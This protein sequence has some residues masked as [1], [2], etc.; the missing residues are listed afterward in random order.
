MSK[1]L[2][3]CRD[4]GTT[5]GLGVYAR[6]DLQP[7]MEVW[8]EP[9]EEIEFRQ[10]EI[11]QMTLEQKRIL[12]RYGMVKQ[13]G[14]VC[15]SPHAKVWL[16]DRRG[17]VDARFCE[18]VPCNYLFINH[19]CEP[20]LVY[21]DDRTLIT[22]RFIKEGEELTYD[23]ATEDYDIVPFECQCGEHNCRGLIKGQE[24]K[25]RELQAK[26]GLHFQSHLLEAIQESSHITALSR[27]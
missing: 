14:T 15:L 23:Y 10:D 24:W 21:K 4:T 16:V 13:D 27:Q 11:K 9:A 1:K 25:K 12:D 3:V 6:M 2:T 7:Q 22:R 18:T 20:N 19:S 17:E 26:Y 5:K 8:R